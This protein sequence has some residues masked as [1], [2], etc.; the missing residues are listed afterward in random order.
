MNLQEQIT[1]IAQRQN[2]VRRFS[3]EMRAASAKDERTLWMFPI[4]GMITG[5]ALFGAGAAFMKLLGA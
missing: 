2:E 4:F 1:Y 3:A 5:G